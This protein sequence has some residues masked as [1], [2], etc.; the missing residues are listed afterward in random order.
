MEHGSCDLDEALAGRGQ[1]LLPPHL[2]EQLE[3]ETLLKTAHRSA[4]GGLAHAE[5]SGR[6]PEATGLGN[7]EKD[8][9]LARLCELVDIDQLHESIL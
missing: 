4:H 3:T 7:G 5:G 8:L 6:P 1:A 2:D 9:D